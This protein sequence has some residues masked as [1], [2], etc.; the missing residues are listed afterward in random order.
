M[1]RQDP[2]NRAEYWHDQR[3]PGLTLMQAAFTT[4]EYAPHAHDALVVAVTEAGGSEVK[5][6]GQVQQAQPNSLFVFNPAEPHAGWMGWSSL[7]RYRSLYLTQSA[8]DVVAE[9]LGLERLPYFTENR[10]DDPQLIDGFL[11]LHRALAASTDALQE[12]ELLQA[13]FGRLFLRHGSG[14]RRPDLPGRD[15][16]LLQRVTDL[17]QE[18]YGEALKLDELGQAAGLR[19]AQLIALFNRCTGMGPHAYLNQV[20]L[21]A[22]CQHLKAG[23]PLADVAA[24]CGFY[25]Q[26]ALNRNFKR[27]Y[28]ITPL[29]YA[30]AA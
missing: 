8:L 7:W 25:D 19:K 3:V 24:A 9:G 2:H 13:S 17:M 1:P 6:R 23:A 10:V 29:Q 21:R 30:Q 26:S 18:R 22:A 11:N 15:R 14:A 20:R 28:G 27:A 12:E 5:S 4:Q 16:R